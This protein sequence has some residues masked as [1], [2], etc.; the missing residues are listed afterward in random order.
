[1]AQNWPW[2]SQIAGKKITACGR[3][4]DSPLSDF[5]VAVSYATIINKPLIKIKSRKCSHLHLI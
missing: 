2:G 1:M 5:I 4:C 3:V